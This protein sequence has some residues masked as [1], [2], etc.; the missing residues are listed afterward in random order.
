MKAFNLVSSSDCHSSSDA[1]KIL[2]FMGLW[3]L[4]NHINQNMEDKNNLAYSTFTDFIGPFAISF[5]IES[6]AVSRSNI[7]GM[8]KLSQR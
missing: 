4:S 5:H 3:S 2:L 7:L 6:L 1:I 8:K